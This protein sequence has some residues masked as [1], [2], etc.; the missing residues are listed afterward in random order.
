M[1][2]GIFLLLGSNIGDKRWHL[3]EAQILINDEIG[4]AIGVSGIY[5]TEPWG[6][7]EQDDFYNQI[8]EIE[9][10]N[11]CRDLLKQLLAIE[12]NMGRIRSKKWGP[13]PI[14]LDILYFGNEIINDPGLII[15][16]PEIQ[17]RKFTLVPL[18]EIAPRF[19][20]PILKKTNKQLLENCKDKLDVRRI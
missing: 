15:P 10:K 5:E 7:T 4:K 2:E 14:D 13:R 9:Y 3:K 12:T 11:T 16:H 6:Y 20:H 18:V 17:N 1:I 8:I 19:L